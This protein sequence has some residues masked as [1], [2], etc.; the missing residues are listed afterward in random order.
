MRW[1]QLIPVIVVAVLLFSV[2]AHAISLPE[3]CTTGNLAECIWRIV[4]DIFHGG[5]EFPN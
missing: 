1:K 4:Y 3:D 2:A 5:G